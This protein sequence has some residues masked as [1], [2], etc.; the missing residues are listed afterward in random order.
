MSSL[1]GLL[2]L[3]RDLSIQ[4][5]K[6]DC[7]RLMREGKFANAVQAGKFLACYQIFSHSF[8]KALFV[9]AAFCDD[10]F[11]IPAFK[12]HF[13]EELGHDDLLME[14][15]LRAGLVEIKKDPI[16]TALT[17][18][19]AYKMLAGNHYEQAILMN[20]CI[21]SAAPT[22][23]K[24]AKPCIDPENRLVHFKAHEGDIDCAHFELGTRLLQGLTEAQYDRLSDV[25]RE[26]WSILNALFK[27]MAEISLALD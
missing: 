12:Q 24:N 27:R 23:Y 17:S 22:I 2:D 14:D 4:F 26:C 19:F 3:N 10:P 7:F 25:L 8:Q 11:F 16:L 1:Q 5:E 13:D 15:R 21:E 18:W 6:N 9:R 20:V